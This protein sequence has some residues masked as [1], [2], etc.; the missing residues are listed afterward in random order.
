M[1]LKHLRLALASLMAAMLLA[2]LPTAASAKRHEQPSIGPLGYVAI[3]DSYTASALP[4]VD[5]AAPPLCGRSLVNYPHLVANAL[6]LTLTD[7]SCGGAQT[8]DI[9]ESQFPGQ[10]PQDSALSAETDVVTIGMGGNDNNLFGTLVNGCT[11]IDF[12]EKAPGKA[13]CKE[14][15]EGFVRETL[16]ADRAPEEAALI[17]VQELAPNATVFVVGYPEITPKHGSCAGVPWTEADLKWFRDKVSIPGNRQIEKTAKQNG[18][19][20]VDT[21]KPSKGHDACQAPGVRWIE[22]IFGSLSPLAFHPNAM[23][24]EGMAAAV[25]QEMLTAGIR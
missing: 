1:G 11:R 15:F 2:A 17:H 13:P 4:P 10:P 5:P 14:A 16:I 23:G 9:T 22:P 3:G 20:F 24:E 7:V 6:G 8:K 25:V 21:F 19:I 12:V 18:A